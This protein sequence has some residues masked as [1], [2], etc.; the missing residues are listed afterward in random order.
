M[1]DDDDQALPLRRVARRAPD[2]GGGPRGR[3]IRPIVI[4]FVHC[5]REPHQA[6]CDGALR[7]RQ[8]DP[9]SLLVTIK[10]QATSGGYLARKRTSPCP[11][12]SGKSGEPK[13][14]QS[15]SCLVFASWSGSARWQMALIAG[16]SKCYTFPLSHF[17]SR[18]NVRY[19]V[20]VSLVTTAVSLSPSPS[21]G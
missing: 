1:H 11:T 18:F 21:H 16:V 4:G 9:H 8:N 17:R 12:P 5:T 20:R 15:H 3:T 19:R 7:S 2:E 6:S 13:P 10:Q 14:S